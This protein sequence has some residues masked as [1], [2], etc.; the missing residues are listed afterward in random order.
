MHAMKTRLF[1]AHFKLKARLILLFKK[2]CQIL[3]RMTYSLMQIFRASAEPDAAQN[4]DTVTIT[5]RAH[6]S[7]GGTEHP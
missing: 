6:A 5:P 3:I 7:A 4:S 1:G 2:S